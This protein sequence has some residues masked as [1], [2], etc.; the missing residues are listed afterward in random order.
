MSNFYCNIC[1]EDVSLQNGKCPKCKTDWGKIVNSKVSDESTP[2]DIYK[3]DIVNNKDEEIQIKE[4]EDNKII[5]EESISNN[6]N[7]FLTWSTIVKII[8]IIIGIIVAIYSIIRMEA[9]DG[10]SILLLIF[11]PLIILYGFILE[12]ILKWKAYM[13][14]TN[15]NNKKH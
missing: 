9:T 2:V 5:T 15:S 14:Y 12:N 3:K 13:L 6:I 7:F 4:F 10:N 11:V 8:M 1:E